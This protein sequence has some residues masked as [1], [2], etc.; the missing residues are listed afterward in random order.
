M[1]EV[2]KIKLVG[3][4]ASVFCFPVSIMYY[5][6]YRIM[7]YNI[8]PSDVIFA[9]V[10]IS[11]KLIYCFILALYLLCTYQSKTP[12]ILPYRANGTKH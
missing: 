1:K 10:R 12:C 7:Y 8:I 2:V 6:L 5:I 11:L 4:L 9:S 3:H